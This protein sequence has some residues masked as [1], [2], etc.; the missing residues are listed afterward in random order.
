M[1]C[2][3]PN[4]GKAKCCFWPIELQK[5]NTRD[6]ARR[7]P[8]KGGNRELLLTTRRR[9]WTPDLRPNKPGHAVRR[10]AALWQGWPE[11]G[12]PDKP[13]G[14]EKNHWESRGK[15]DFE[16]EG[17]LVN[18]ARTDFGYSNQMSPPV[19]ERRR[20]CHRLLTFMYRARQ[21]KEA[22]EASSR[23]LSLQRGNPPA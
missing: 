14:T 10:W 20:A 9:S 5:K 2:V 23:K 15:G 16:T 6:E 17:V 1:K 19:V 21:E 4:P 18:R 8:Q 11:R 12:G 22:N 3:V 13:Q 7:D